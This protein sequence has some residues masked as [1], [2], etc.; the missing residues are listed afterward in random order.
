MRYCGR[1]PAEVAGWA[2]MAVVI[3][4]L[5][6]IPGCKTDVHSQLLE[7]ELRLQE[8]QIYCLQDKLENKCYQLDQLNDE[9]AS[10]RRQLG[11]VDAKGNSASFTGS[12]CHDWA[13]HIEKPHFCAQGNILTGKEVVGAMA[14]S[15]EQLQKQAKGGL[16]DWLAWFG[17]I[18]LEAQERTRARVEFSIDKAR[19]LDRLRGHMNARQEK[20]LLRML[21]EGPA[22][23]AGGLSAGNYIRVAR[24]SPATARRDLADMVAKGALSR[25]GERRYTRYRL[26]IPTRRTPY[27][28]IGPNGRIVTAPEN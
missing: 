6:L 4:L 23:F 14:S 5:G 1:Q 24:T 28:S 19:L 25:T 20:V 16:C 7:R 22:G 17:G 15:F 9:N 3:G 10:L 12:D 18:V 26:T 2:A 27:I 13:G 8:D 11:I 21:R